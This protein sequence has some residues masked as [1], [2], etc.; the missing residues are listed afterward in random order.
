MSLELG[1][2]PV[3]NSVPMYAIQAHCW[4][5]IVAVETDARRRRNPTGI[6]EADLS[7]KIVHSRI[8]CRRRNDARGRVVANQAHG[9]RRADTGR[10]SIRNVFKL[11][12]KG[13]EFVRDRRSV[14]HHQA[15][16]FALSDSW[17]LV[18]SSWPET[19]RFLSDAKIV[20]YWPGLRTVA[21]SCHFVRF[22][23][24][25]VRYQSVMST[26]TASVFFS[27]IQSERSPSW[28]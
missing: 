6:V 18:C 10:G 8:L 20:R 5:L 1:I 28:S 11:R 3:V 7:P 24:S 16:V 23:E 26:G 22:D 21:G 13:C 12:W 27:S 17:K 15:E 9:R 4:A 2:W 25:S 14:G 19:A